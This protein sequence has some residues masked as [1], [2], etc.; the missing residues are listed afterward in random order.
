MDPEVPISPA[1][2]E[3]CAMGAVL[4]REKKAPFIIVSGGYV[5]PFRTKYCEAQEMKI[6]LTDSLHI[7]EDAIMMEPHARHTTTNVRNAN[8]I[9]YN[10][11]IPASMPVLGVTSKSHIDYIVAKRFKSGCMKEMGYLPFEELKRISETEVEFYPSM[12]SL[13][14][15]AVTP[16]DP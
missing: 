3:R 16:L 2:K 9:I 10:Q 14:I 13:Q 1:N 8:R 7:P 11:H 12:L 6:Y 5:H 15:N 4:F